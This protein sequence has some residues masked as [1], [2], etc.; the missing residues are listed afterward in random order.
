MMALDALCAAILPEMVLTIAKK[1][2]AKE[3]WDTIATMRVGDDH[4]KKVMTQQLRQ[5]FD[6]T[7][8]NDGEAVEDYVL[9]LRGMVAHLAMLGEEVKD[10]EIIVKMLRSLPPRFK[11]ITIAIKRLLYVSIM[12]I[13][14]VWVTSRPPS[15]RLSAVQGGGRGGWRR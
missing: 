5:K 1:D 3:S 15:L 2:T 14:D 13:A 10:G 12:S 4:M 11:Q 7:T 6:L 8:F 9:C